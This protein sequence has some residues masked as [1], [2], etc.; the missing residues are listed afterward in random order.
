M[1]RWCS[2]NPTLFQLHKNSKEDLKYNPQNTAHTTKKAVANCS[3]FWK[4]DL[5]EA[6]YFAYLRNTQIVHALITRLNDRHSRLC[7]WVCHT[8]EPELVYN[9]VIIS[10]I[11]G[12]RHDGIVVWTEENYMTGRSNRHAI[13]IITI[14]PL[15]TYSSRWLFEGSCWF[16]FWHKNAP[17]NSFMIDRVDYRAWWLLITFIFMM[18]CLEIESKYLLLLSQ[19]FKDP[20]ERL[21]HT[22]L[23][24]SAYSTLSVVLQAIY[25]STGRG[26]I[27]IVI[28][29]N[30]CITALSHSTGTPTT[31]QVLWPCATNLP[32]TTTRTLLLFLRTDG[33]GEEAAKEM[34]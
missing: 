26:L 17:S 13:M 28:Y 29:A 19:M 6:L 20:G 3:Q 15:P 30:P 7:L 2:N 11:H 27:P 24:H 5:F 32:L 4:E 33:Q 23:L 18:G 21:A 1:W 31:A 9:T 8:S 10:G 14:V 16:H 12:G 22:N 25:Q 34:R